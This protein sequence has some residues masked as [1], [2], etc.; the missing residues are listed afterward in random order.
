MLCL[1]EVI[2]CFCEVCIPNEEYNYGKAQGW[3]L[4]ITYN[5]VNKPIYVNK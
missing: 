1:F 3:S 5:Y 2:I 4:A